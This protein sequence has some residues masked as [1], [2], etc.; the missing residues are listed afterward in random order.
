[1]N[2]PLT[3]AN[4]PNNFFSMQDGRGSHV[5]S[6]ETTV[7]SNLEKVRKN[8][9]PATAPLGSSRPQIVVQ[10]PSHLTSEALNSD[11]DGVATSTALMTHK[12]KPNDE[13]SQNT[14][15]K[16]AQSSIKSPSEQSNYKAR[17]ASQ[18]KESSRIVAQSD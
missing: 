2:Q 18:S 14:T 7:L 12:Y 9:P 1:M 10:P 8:I 4:I 16:L 17:S 15:P 5:V 11:L 3:P 13:S 6:A